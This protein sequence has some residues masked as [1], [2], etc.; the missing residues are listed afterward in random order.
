MKQHVSHLATVLE[1]LR[2]HQL[3]LKPLKCLFGQPS[4]AY[5]GH[6]ISAMRV[7]MDSSKISAISDWLTPTTD[8]A[9]HGFF[10]LARY[11]HKFFRHF[12]IIARPLMD[13]L[14]SDSF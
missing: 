4:I 2:T 14:R 11:Y 7:A 12:G 10:S 8:R 1:L 13:L 6:I 3:K 5:L 9:L